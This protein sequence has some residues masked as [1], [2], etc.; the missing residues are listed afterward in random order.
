MKLTENV[1]IR[2]VTGPIWRAFGA[3]GVAILSHE[4]ACQVRFSPTG[5]VFAS[6]SD[7]GTIKIYDTVNV[8]IAFLFI[9]GFLNARAPNHCT[10]L[11]SCTQ[12]VRI[13]AQGTTCMVY[14]IFEK[15]AIPDIHRGGLDRK[16]LGHENWFVKAIVRIQV[17]QETKENQ[18]VLPCKATKGLGWRPVQYRRLYPTLNT[19]FSVVMIGTTFCWFGTLEQEPC[20]ENFQVGLQYQFMY[21]LSY[22]H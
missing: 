16:M 14:Q 2:C 4:L 5:T 7:D 18:Q 6:G 17:T 9:D 8:K 22:F 13:C 1:S 20:S 11:W 15:W 10:G 12:Y 3:P 19:M 21:L